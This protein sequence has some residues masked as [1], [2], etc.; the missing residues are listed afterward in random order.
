MLAYTAATST[1]TTFL[2]LQN[3]YLFFAISMILLGFHVN[4]WL[5]FWGFALMWGTWILSKRHLISVLQESMWSFNY[6]FFFPIWSSESTH[7]ILFVW[8]FCSLLEIGLSSEFLLRSYERFRFLSCK[9]NLLQL[10][11]ECDGD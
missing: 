7:H 6:W 8:E 11:P 1:T 9:S 2:L 3:P 5:I 4:F 10:E